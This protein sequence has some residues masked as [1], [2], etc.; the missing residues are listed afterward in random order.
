M[1]VWKLKGVNSVVSGSAVKGLKAD[2]QPLECVMH[3]ILN[4]KDVGGC[5]ALCCVENKKLQVTLMANLWPF[6]QKSN[7]TV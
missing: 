5:D 2:L 1:F 4:I 6:L 3:I 7:K